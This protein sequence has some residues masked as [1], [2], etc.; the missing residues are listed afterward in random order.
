VYFV[1]TLAS[2]GGSRMYRRKFKSRMQDFLHVL[3][4]PAL[5]VFLLERSKL[6]VDF[7]C[8]AASLPFHI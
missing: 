7:R 1:D 3:R 4:S 5:F 8:A 6:K 2:F